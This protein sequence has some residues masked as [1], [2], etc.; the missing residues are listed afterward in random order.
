MIIIAGGD[1]FVYGS[2][3]SDCKD[4]LKTNI[5]GHSL[6][7]FP[8][9]LAKNFT[10]DCVAWPGYSNES[11]A[12]TV[13]AQCNEYNNNCGVIVSWTFPGRYEFRFTY[14]TGQRKSPWYPFNRWT[15]EE[16]DN[17]VKHFKNNSIEV[18]YILNKN[19]NKAKKNGLLEFVKQFY[20]HV[21]DGEY[22]EV[23]C[24][25]KEIVYLQNYLK[26]NNIPYLFTCADNSL[27]NNYTIENADVYVKSL[28]GQIDNTKWF[29]FPEGIKTNETKTP[30]GFYQWALENKYPVGT[31]HPLE[32]AHSAAAEL[33][34]E[35][36]YEL[37][38]KP[39]EQ[40]SIRNQISS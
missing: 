13:I 29:W 4:N 20:K 19:Y 15:I 3:L 30:R 32:Q 28:L 35:K 11:I 2:E 25:L 23:Y 33:I 38:T 14:D 1:S 31:T 10:Y 9:L 22:W 40:N 27:F 39:L 6:N 7:T 8:S 18:E 24:S 34:K 26:I 12:R 5:Y 36:F 37:V 21:G 16:P 17:V